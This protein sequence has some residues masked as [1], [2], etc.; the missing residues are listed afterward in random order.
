MIYQQEKNQFPRK[1]KFFK[2]DLSDYK[3]F[4]N[5]LNVTIFYIAGQSSG[6][7]SFDDPVGDLKKN[8]ISTLNLIKY[9]IKCK[10][11]K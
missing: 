2:F 11:K 9:G 3:N 1:I 10:A 4:K 7:V 6:D 5:Y 8:T